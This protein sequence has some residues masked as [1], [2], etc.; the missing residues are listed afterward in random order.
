MKV[1]VEMPKFSRTKLIPLIMKLGDYLKKGFDHYTQLKIAGSEVDVDL[2]TAFIS[3]QMDSWN[4]KMGKKI[5]LD[6]ETK[7]AA[8][9]FLAGVAFNL[10]NEG[11]K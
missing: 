7:I 4:P 11:E 5:L 8:A 10:A 1:K 9:R 3:R 6:P 2:L